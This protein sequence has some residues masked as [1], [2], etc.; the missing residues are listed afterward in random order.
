MFIRKGHFSL[1]F[2]CLY[3]LA[4]KLEHIFSILFSLS[5]SNKT[6]CNR[7]KNFKEFSSFKEVLE[8]EV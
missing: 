6:P 1:S 2:A 4:L 8:K 3:H 5:F 7:Y